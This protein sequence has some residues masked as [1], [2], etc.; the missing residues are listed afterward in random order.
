MKWASRLLELK[1]PTDPNYGVMLQIAYRDSHQGHTCYCCRTLSKVLHRQSLIFGFTLW[2]FCLEIN[3]TQLNLLIYGS[4]EVGLN[5]H[6]E[7]IIKRKAPLAVTSTCELTSVCVMCRW[8]NVIIKRSTSLIVHDVT[9]QLSVCLS[10]CVCCSCSTTSR[11]VL[12][13]SCTNWGSVTNTSLLASRSHSRVDN[14]VW[15]LRR[16]SSGRRASSAAELRTRMLWR[17]CTRRLDADR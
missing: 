17:C 4:C 2:T 16:S 6:R 12:P 14:S 5:K 8:R 13:S 11:V 9:G 15:R 7:H 10:V 3:S 1:R